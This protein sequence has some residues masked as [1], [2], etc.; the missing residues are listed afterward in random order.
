MVSGHFGAAVMVELVG[1]RIAKTTYYEPPVW[2]AQ[3]FNESPMHMLSGS[4]RIF[5]EAF[6]QNQRRERKVDMY[7]ILQGLMRKERRDRQDGR[8]VSALS[9]VRRHKR[10]QP[11]RDKVIPRVELHRSIEM[12]NE[13]IKK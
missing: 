9:E 4:G 7:M 12:S 1:K 13:S 6:R 2:G 11:R 8:R 3:N 5:L 10:L